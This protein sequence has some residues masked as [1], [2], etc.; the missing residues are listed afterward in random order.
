DFH[1]VL[2]IR[3]G[4][5]VTLS[6]KAGIHAGKI[7]YLSPARVPVQDARHTHVRIVVRCVPSAEVR[8]D[9]GRRT[10]RGDVKAYR[11]RPVSR[12]N[13]V[14]GSG[15]LLLRQSGTSR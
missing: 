11:R 6:R 2:T 1:H 10:I 4:M 12:Y 13:A 9:E 15:S 7:R 5:V 3:S 14:S 8:S